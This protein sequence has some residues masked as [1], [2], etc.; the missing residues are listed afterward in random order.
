MGEL[1]ALITKN[2]TIWKR[3]KVSLIAEYVIVIG[4]AMVLGIFKH[5]STT[6]DKPATSYLNQ[7]MPLGIPADYSDP[8]NV[9]A[10]YAFTFNVYSNVS[11]QSRGFFTYPMKACM[12]STDANRKTGGYVALITDHPGMRNNL[13]YII[14]NAN[15][16][17]E[18]PLSD[19][20]PELQNFK[21]KNF[22]SL[23]DMQDYVTDPSYGDPDP[24]VPYM[25]KSLC[26]GIYFNSTQKN[27]WKYSVSY[28]VSGNPSWYD[29]MALDQGQVARFKQEVADD[30]HWKNQIGSG[31]AS[32]QEIISNLIYY[33]DTGATPT[34]SAK[35]IQTPT[36]GYRSSDLFNKTNNGDMSFFIMFPLMINFLKLVYMILNEK[37]KRIAENLRNMGMS[38]YKHYFSWL[39]F[40]TMVLLS[41]TLIWA[42]IAKF[43]FFQGS[44]FIFVWLLMLLPGLTL[45]SCSFFIA[46]VFEKAKNG[47]IFS[48]IML[49][50]FDVVRTAKQ[51]ITNPSEQLVK[52]MSLAPSEGV[53]SSS[54]LMV[55]LESYDNG[56]GFEHYNVLVNGFK[57]CWFVETQIITIVFFFVLGLYLDQV[58]PSEIGVKRH[59]LFF[60]LDCCAKKNRADRLPDGREPLIDAKVEKPEN[61][62]EIDALLSAQTM[63][64]KTLQIQ[65][66]RKVYSNGKV[67]VE[68]L[69]LEMFTDQIFA[70]L[71]H[72]GAGKTT[73]ISMIS[74]LFEQ[75]SGNI[76]ILGRDT[77]EE[78]KANRKILGVCPQTNPIYEN[79]TCKEHLVLY[80]TIK[81]G[82]KTD[83]P[84]S[85]REIDLILQDLDLY[86][87]K[88]YP[89]SK[90]SGGQKRKL[91][92]AIAFIGGSKVILLDEPTSG[93][94]TYA[95]RF[96]WDMLKN[97]KKDRIIILSTH[98]MDEADYLGD[99]IGIM[100][101]GKLITCGS[102]L[103]LKKRFGI[104]YDLT[105]VK[106]SAEVSSDKIEQ[107]IVD[108]IPSAK[109]AGDISM[110]VKF[111][112]PATE[113]SKFEELFKVFE[114]RKEEYGI[115][116]F[117][118]SLTTL[119]EVFLRVA[120]LD[121]HTGAMI[122]DKD[123]ILETIADERFELNDIREKNPT[124]IFWM[125]F[126]ALCKKRFIY[127]SRDKRGLVCEMVL[128]VII[129]LAG[130]FMT[131]LKFIAP[132]ANG[133]LPYNLVSNNTE[134]WFGYSQQT[135]P[136]AS[137]MEPF[138]K[139]II[140]DTNSQQGS[141]LTYKLYPTDNITQFD[142]LLQVNPS[143]DR[144]YSLYFD[145]CDPVNNIFKYNCFV[146][147]TGPFSIN[148]CFNLAENLI[149]KTLS[150]P[151]SQITI[152]SVPFELTKQVAS[153]QNT[154]LGF[155]TALLIS[156][157]YAFIP[158]SVI[159][160]IVKEREN[161][162]KH[163]QIVSG[164]S[165]LAYW[166]SNIT[167]DFLKYLVPATATVIIMYIYDVTIFVNSTGLPMTITI[168]FLFG[169]S[170][171]NFT[172][173]L[174]FAFK[175]P[176]KAQFIIFLLNYLG[177]S[178][179][180]VLSFILRLLQSTRNVQVYFIEFVLR[181][182]PIYSISFGLFST[183]NAQ[184]WQIVFQ[185]PS[186]PGPWN[187]YCALWSII[188][189]I[190]TA[191]VYFLIILLIEA[192]GSK[193]AKAVGSTN[194]QERLDYSDEDEDVTKER[195]QVENGQNY[196]V[197]V[198][199]LM[200]EYV[201]YR[202]GFCKK[203]RPES[204]KLAVK[205]VSFGVQKGE[206]FGLLGTNGAGKTSTFKVLSGEILPN[207]GQAQIS[208][209]N[210][211]TDMK[212][213]GSLIGYCP[214]FDALLE[215]LTAKEHLEL[216][217]AIKGIPK[218]MRAKL[219]ESKLQQLNL[220]QYENVL[221]G[222]YSGGNKRKLSVAIALLG[223]PPIILL[224]EPS[225]G[226]DPEARR[227]MWSIVSQIST[228]NKTSS[229]ILTTHSME[230]AEALSSKLAIMVEGKIK[231]IGPV[232]QL[233]SKYG[234]G[235]EI[236]VKIRLPT[237]EEIAELKKLSGTLEERITTQ[238]AAVNLLER[239]GV[240]NAAAEFAPNGRCFHFAQQ[241]VL[242]NNL[243]YHEDQKSSCTVYLN[244]RTR[245]SRQRLSSL[246]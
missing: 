184:I 11:A 82:G 134:I 176:S 101:K 207:Y 117:G 203:K 213:I 128:P 230:E 86:D 138:F 142:H 23:Q 62:E 163:Q 38:L 5:F 58:W 240:V 59:P 118:I 169:L 157:A 3:N 242:L 220:K 171:M 98:Y 133:I 111:Q 180:M 186:L 27:N 246:S 96:L 167:V 28:N 104:G 1:S 144:F 89:A 40:N 227:F 239:T 9:A 183:A 4:F 30:Y 188:Y 177:G 31:L 60:I 81:N 197:R 84:V 103:F 18:F 193:I 194:P 126:K 136:A 56:M 67:A 156:I 132:P 210:V 129:I 232:Q 10:T 151:S 71:G 211:E 43:V 83:P 44:N 53:S 77:R 50:L 225:S 165:I 121:E 49:F 66:L 69:N 125:H 178:I 221:A 130:M 160:V 72:N 26:F 217:A 35:L 196:A 57:Y 68:N 107:L 234:Q 80:A 243:R 215:N 161:N 150:D 2:L 74:G 187:R 158:A 87:K 85:E 241:V 137:N 65:N 114:Q 93:M 175:S 148:L 55:M 12:I 73:T 119:E 75:T 219:I 195:L 61:F 91:C 162:V 168:F 52:W 33:F 47:I 17:N 78:A 122:S 90:L 236:E 102:S 8:V 228:Q 145:A 214:Q 206:C 229:V 79:L 63:E 199:N 106:T 143:V 6:T 51:A 192:K 112:L 36:N 153:F 189:L 208:G 48:F 94:D 245:M 135:A 152:A 174:S 200:I 19:L 13:T 108:R 209:F 149:Y 109:K 116:T 170:L 105:V 224:D 7:S 159:T 110:E 141:Q 235:F 181:L 64:N 124:S 146:N 100:G 32:M 131:T 191:I 155:I 179:L 20:P 42:T 76:N 14:E 233:K 99:R 15:L 231:C 22:N 154:A 45:Q 25:N 70:L 16:T 37:E 123:R 39:I 95:R 198:Y 120:S 185:L 97:Y 172:Y 115:Q 139:Q 127:F 201:I 226:M 41:T 140:S 182:L 238:E 34:V 164:V 92:V 222:T 21:V 244:M 237:P 205:G 173:L 202:D 46:G 166:L 223:N 88:N 218:H 113:S 216:Y 212:T 204:T 190:L 147:T 24:D 29:L 54:S